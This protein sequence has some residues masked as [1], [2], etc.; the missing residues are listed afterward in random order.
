MKLTIQQ[1]YRANGEST[2]VQGVTPH[3]HIPSLRDEAEIGEGKMDNAMKFDK[4]PA[5][6]HDMYPRIPANLLSQL[7]TRSAARR[8]ADPKFAKQ[9]ERIKK[10][11]DRKAKHTIS[12]NE[13][14]FKAEFIAED[15]DGKNADE[16]KPKDKKKNNRYTER[17]AW[18][19]DYYND[20][21][22]KIVGDY[23]SIDSKVFAAAPVPALTEN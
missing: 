14:K 8:K 11:A 10:Y 13:E 16:D 7:E 5:Q 21:I 3:I 18:E 17:P 22:V 9:D 6:K 2:Q 1:F 20:E 4:V 12:L 19:P 23:L 15:E